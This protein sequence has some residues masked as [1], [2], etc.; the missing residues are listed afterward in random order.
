[1]TNCSS[2]RFRV[3]CGAAMWETGCIVWR[4][5][6]SFSAA[7]CGV[8]CREEVCVGQVQK[9]WGRSDEKS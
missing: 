7:H 9:E 5:Q 4:A 3:T 1:M 6:Q 8:L 2:G